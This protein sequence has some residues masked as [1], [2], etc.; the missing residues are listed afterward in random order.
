[1]TNESTSVSTQQSP[2][3]ATP[4]PLGLEYVAGA[5]CEERGDTVGTII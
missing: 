3:E 2:L 1:M 5:L 4:I